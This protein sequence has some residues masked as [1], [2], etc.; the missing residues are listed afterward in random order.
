MEGRRRERPWERVGRQRRAPG[1]GVRAAAS[2]APLS[3]ALHW[4]LGWVPWGSYSGKQREKE[5]KILNK[6]HLRL[7]NYGQLLLV[8]T[9]PPPRFHG[10]VC[11][12]L[13]EMLLC[14][15]SIFVFIC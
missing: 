3:Q 14:V 11:Y 10:T 6:E 2:S 13:L 15:N 1:M 5:L 4:P 12:S 8:H 7:E 9:P